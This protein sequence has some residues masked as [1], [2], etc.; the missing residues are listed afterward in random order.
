MIDLTPRL[1]C[2]ANLV[3]ADVAAD[4]GCDHAYAA[5]TIIDEKRAKKRGVY[6]K[7]NGSLL[8]HNGVDCIIMIII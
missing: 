1:R 6:I 7:I 8:T 2:I 5:I 4:I 3:D